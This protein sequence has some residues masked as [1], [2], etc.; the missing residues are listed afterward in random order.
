MGLSPT[1]SASTTGDLESVYCDTSR[2]KRNMYTYVQNCMKFSY[3]L[4]I[5]SRKLNKKTVL[6]EPGNV[7]VY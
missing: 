5:S 1:P 6:D 7:S 4:A 3:I 2:Y